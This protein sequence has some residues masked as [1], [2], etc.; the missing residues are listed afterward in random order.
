MGTV[1]VGITVVM[2][3]DQ[4]SHLSSYHA[5]RD[6]ERDCSTTIIGIHFKIAK[7]ALWCFRVCSGSSA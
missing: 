2:K 7:G 6:A 4:L 3:Y 1:G 5:R